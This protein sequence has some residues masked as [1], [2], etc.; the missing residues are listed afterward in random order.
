MFLKDI[1]AMILGQAEEGTRKMAYGFY[2]FNVAAIG[3]FGAQVGIWVG[4]E[5]RLSAFQDCHEGA[6]QAML[7]IFSGVILGNVAEH[8]FR[9]V[10]RGKPEAATE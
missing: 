1:L 6:V 8:G 3:W 10:R 5:A 4:P 2:A 7:I 9:A